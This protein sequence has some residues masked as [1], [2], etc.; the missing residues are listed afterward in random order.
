MSASAILRTACL[1]TSSREDNQR[2]GALTA[3]CWSGSQRL[4]CAS[5]ADV[6]PFLTSSGFT[7]MTLGTKEAEMLNA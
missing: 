2:K 1:Q 6:N 3:H 5:A 4:D 7:E